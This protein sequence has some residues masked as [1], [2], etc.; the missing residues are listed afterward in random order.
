M[1]QLCIHILVPIHQRVKRKY[2][3]AILKNSDNVN[4]IREQIEHCVF[5]IKTT[6]QPVFN[7]CCLLPEY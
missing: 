3:R 2:F 5:I 6:C 7:F 4:I 1:C